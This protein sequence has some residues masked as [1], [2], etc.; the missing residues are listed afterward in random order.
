LMVDGSVD[1]SGL[2]GDG[3]PPLEDSASSLK[4]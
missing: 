1:T 4:A 3:K 2:A